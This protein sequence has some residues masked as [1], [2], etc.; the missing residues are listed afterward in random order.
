MKIKIKWIE[1]VRRRPVPA[2]YACNISLDNPPTE[3]WSCIVSFPQQ[4]RTLGDLYLYR[5]EYLDVPDH[6]FL[7]EGSRTVAE[8][9][10]SDET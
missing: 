3:V 2:Q 4:V 6:F 10:R 5:C 1:G 9:W 8:A 7:T